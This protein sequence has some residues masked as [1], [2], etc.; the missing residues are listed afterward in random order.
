MSIGEVH[1]T[2]QSRRMSSKENS[3]LNQISN[4][5]EMKITMIINI[6]VDAKGVKVTFTALLIP[7]CQS[8][9]IVQLMILKC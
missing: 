8:L 1:N 6:E 4:H 9:V 5:L 3:R 2:S 7:G